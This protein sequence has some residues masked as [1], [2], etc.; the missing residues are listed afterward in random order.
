[1]EELLENMSKSIKDI[2]TKI[3]KKR[4]DIKKLQADLAKL[5]ESRYV[6]L[7]QKNNARLCYEDICNAI[8][9]NP[10]TGC[11]N[12][13]DK[14]F[15]KN[16][17]MYS[18]GGYY[19]IT[20]NKK[21]YAAH[22]IAYLLMNK[23]FPDYNIDH[24]D[25]NGLNN[26]WENLREATPKENGRNKKKYGC[27]TSGYKGVTWHENRKKWVSQATL[28]GKTHYLGGYNTAEDAYDAYLTFIKKNHGDF[29]N[30]G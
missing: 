14:V 3:K 13:V 11:F 1:M 27:N 12:F 18:H 8:E 4:Q 20:I 23:K 30:E 15:N 5:K 24:I 26:K 17:H 6:T 28:D 10:I 2:E 19:T 29:Y 25:N 16:I 22:R 7:Q 21:T 9:Y